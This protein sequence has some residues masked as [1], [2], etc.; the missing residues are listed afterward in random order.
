MASDIF[1]K[2]GDIKGE[3]LDAKHKDE[4]EVLSYSWGVTQRRLH[5][6]RKRRRRG[7]GD[8]PRS[9]VR[10]QHRQGVAGPD[11][12]VRHRRPPQG[13]DDHAPQGRQGTAG[14]PHRQDERRHRHGRD[15]RRQRRRR[16]RRTSAWRS[17][18]SPSSTSRRSRTARSTP[19]SSSS[20]TSRRRRKP[21]Q[22]RS[23]QVA[24]PIPIP[25]PL[26]AWRR[27]H[28]PQRQRRQARRR[29]P[30]RRRTSKHKNEIEVLGWSWGMQ[31]KP[32]LGGGSATGKATMRELRI[33]KARR[34][35]VHRADVG[36]AH[37]RADQEGRADHA[38]GRQDAARVLDD[39]DRGRPRDVARH[40]GRRRASAPRSSSGSAFRSTRSPSST[41]P[42]PRR[43]RAGRHQLR[44]RVDGGLSR[45][46][47]RTR[48]SGI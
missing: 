34:Q 42:G 28:V 5:G 29:S 41:R 47:F 3:S 1:A 21:S 6:P 36:A 20:T 39:Q 46:L 22:T 25:P 48:P 40:R 12:G 9:V 44:G 33:I 8:V 24:V 31:G 27:G 4:I 19:A 10:P 11:A 38:E 35:G 37:Q 2:L 43:Q 15:A 18:R 13:S 14:V 16:I 23:T 17:R 32:S 7:Q 26:G 45:W 30:A